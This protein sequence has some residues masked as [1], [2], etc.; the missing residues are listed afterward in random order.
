MNEREKF[1]KYIKSKK[2]NILRRKVLNRDNYTCQFCNSKKD[3]IVHHITYNNLFNETLNDLITICYKCH[4]KVHRKGDINTPEFVRVNYYEEKRNRLNIISFEEFN[5]LISKS[6]N[7]DT[8]FYIKLGF[9]LCLKANEIANIKKKDVDIERGLIKIKNRVIPIINP[10][11]KQTNEFLTDNFKILGVRSIE[12]KIKKL[13]KKVLKKDINLNSL[14]HSGA[15]F[16]YDNG[17]PIELLSKFLGHRNIKY[18]AES[19]CTTSSYVKMI[20][21]ILIL[22]K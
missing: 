22:T 2:W 5:L 9:L 17:M 19:Y 4:I 16:Y 1:Q 8:K 7:E 6:K 12:K 15:V 18:T 3:L 11:I 21:K 13:S 14:R 20:R 10:I